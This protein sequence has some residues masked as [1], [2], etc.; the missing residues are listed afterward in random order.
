MIKIY[1]I[2]ILA[3]IPIIFNS[4]SVIWGGIVAIDNSINEGPHEIDLDKMSKLKKGKRIILELNDSTQISG[5]YYGMETEGD[6]SNQKRINL[7]LENEDKRQINSSDVNKYTYIDEGGNVW[8][9][10]AIGAMFDAI[11]IYTMLH[12]HNSGIGLMLNGPL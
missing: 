4:C 11:F 9:A 3:L 12:S 7:K 10:A 1:Q 8:L 2:M 6:K 5:T